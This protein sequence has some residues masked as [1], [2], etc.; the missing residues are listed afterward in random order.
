MNIYVYECAGRY[1]TYMYVYSHDSEKRLSLLPVRFFRVAVYCMFLSSINFV[2][3]SIVSKIFIPCMNM[4][5][6]LFSFSFFF[7]IFFLFI[8][9]FMQLR[10]EGEEGGRAPP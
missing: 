4:I 2:F 9:L 7:I 10:P 1:I 8:P 6:C 5:L 3:R